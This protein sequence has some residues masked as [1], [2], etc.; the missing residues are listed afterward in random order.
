MYLEAA[1]VR[2]LAVARPP[3]HATAPRPPD[4]RA[5]SPPWME[6]ASSSRRP[7]SSHSTQFLQPRA[8]LL[9]AVGQRVR[10][11]FLGGLG[12]PE[13]RQHQ[14][15]EVHVVFPF[16]TVHKTMSTSCR[17]SSLR[18]WRNGTSFTRSCAHRPYSGASRLHQCQD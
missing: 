10:L 2:N 9:L 15:S 12:K 11:C 14:A 5:V 4:V 1:G 17:R 6:C 16:V 7:P 3:A 8:Q 13:S 18:K